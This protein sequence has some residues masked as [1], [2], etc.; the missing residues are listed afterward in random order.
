VNAYRAANGLPPIGDSAID[1]SALSVADMRVSKSIRLQGTMK[2]E[3]LLQVFNFMNTR[4]LQDQY[5]GGR[6]N[7]AL[8]TNFGRIFTARPMAQG[9][10]AAKLVW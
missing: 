5:G 10:V 9:E 2:L 1:S 6:V 7:N 8:S 4:N 3:L